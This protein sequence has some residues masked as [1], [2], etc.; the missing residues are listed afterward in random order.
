M[1]SVNVC[2]D[3]LDEVINVYFGFK[4]KERRQRVDEDC[5]EDLET[6]GDDYKSD[7]DDEFEEYGRNNEVDR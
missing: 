6:A 4:R 1:G 7:K 5:E 3:I 2:F